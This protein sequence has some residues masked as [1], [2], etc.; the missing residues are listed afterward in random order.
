MS[1]L[2]N[3]FSL[4]ANGQPLNLHKVCDSFD[5]FI[6]KNGIASIFSCQGRIINGRG[7]NLL[8]VS[9]SYAIAC[10]QLQNSHSYLYIGVGDE[11]AGGNWPPPNSNILG[12]I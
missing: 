11:E 10:A 7:V 6:R 5:F 2:D 1:T 8:T 4:T 3:P 12:Q 9:L